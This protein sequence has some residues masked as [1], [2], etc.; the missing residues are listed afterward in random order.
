MKVR[1]ITKV[2]VTKQGVKDYDLEVS[3]YYDTLC[4][5]TKERIR[6][7][8]ISFEKSLK[9]LLYKNKVTNIYDVKAE[10]TVIPLVKV[11]SED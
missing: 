9:G 3:H 5:E 8:T 4:F 10:I 11:E 1:D 6:N 2:I 7:A